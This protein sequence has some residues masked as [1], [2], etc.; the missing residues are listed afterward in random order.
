MNRTSI[1]LLTIALALSIP[2]NAR[3]AKSEN[4]PALVS[5]VAEAK[6]Q[7]TWVSDAHQWF[8]DKSLDS[9]ET[10]DL[11]F[12]IAPKQIKMT[13]N[14]SGKMESDGFTMDLG[15]RMTGN[16]AYKKTGNTIEM[17]SNGNKPKF[18]ITQFKFHVDEET[19]AALNAAGV[20]DDFFKKELEKQFTTGEIN[21]V[22]KTIEGTFTITTLTPTTLVLTDTEGESIKFKRTK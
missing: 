4:S 7:G 11:V 21:E 6:L 20:T 2:C 16:Y 8:N 18:S 22:F 12:E 9:F 15:F 17:K 1:L 19:R 5:T 10:A 3:L 13:F 14:L